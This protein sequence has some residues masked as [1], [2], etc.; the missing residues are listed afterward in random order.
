VTV[1]N[2]AVRVTPLTVAVRVLT[3]PAVVPVQTAVYYPGMKVAL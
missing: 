3:V 2:L 1:R